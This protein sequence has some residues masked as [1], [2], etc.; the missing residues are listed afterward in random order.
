MIAATATNA[1]AHSADSAAPAP[2]HEDNCVDST[3]RDKQED[4]DVGRKVLRGE[5]NIAA[6]EVMPA[7]TGA[8]E[9]EEQTI[10]Q[11]LRQTVKQ[12]SQDA[13]QLSP[14]ASKELGER[15]HKMEKSAASDSRTAV[16]SDSETAEKSVKE[17]F[18][19]KR[20]EP[21]QLAGDGEQPLDSSSAADTQTLSIAVTTTA[22]KAG[23]GEVEQN[24]GAQSDSPT[25]L[26][27]AL[28]SSEDILGGKEP[29][30]DFSG[31]PE[32]L[33]AH[34]SD[35]QTDPNP[36]Q[37][38][39]GTAASEE[40]QREHKAKTGDETAPLSDSQTSS[41]PFPPPAATLGDASNDA[42]ADDATA[43]NSVILLDSQS[44]CQTAQSTLDQAA[45]EP[46]VS[47]IARISVSDPQSDGQGTHSPSREAFKEASI[48]DTAAAAIAAKDP[49]ASQRAHHEAHGG[50][51]GATGN[52]HLSPESL[53]KIAGGSVVGE[54]ANAMP[55]W[56]GPVVHLSTD[57]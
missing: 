51:D 4:T 8:L 52:T 49:D 40:L 33:A 42:T 36:F 53:T 3:R 27:P 41:R 13:N 15:A 43:D 57:L 18:L 39:E 9:D 10:R 29:Q 11:Q 50:D 30:T 28:L 21:E 17:S 46:A 56:Q 32:S 12:L 25:H 20:E 26:S 37:P 14:E 23:S 16:M 47:S 6:A 7:P 31:A 35:S 2:P 19:P 55:T 34:A 38:K 22:E 44:D 24:A 45:E 48:D 54:D 1:S 5:G